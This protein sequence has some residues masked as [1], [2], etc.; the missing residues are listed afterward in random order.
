MWICTKCYKMYEDDS[1]MEYCTCGGQ[2]EDGIKCVDC[3]EYF[4]EEDIACGGNLCDNCL[5]KHITIDNVAEYVK[6]Y[7][8]EDDIFDML[9]EFIFEDKDHYSEWL[10]EKGKC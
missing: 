9:K 3:G 5:E 1:D 4:L 2:L 6:Q 7:K 8:L 10:K